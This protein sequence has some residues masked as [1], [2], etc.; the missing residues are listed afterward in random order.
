MRHSEPPAET[1]VPPPPRPLAELPTS[2]PFGRMTLPPRR[3]LR[4]GIA[5]LRGRVVAAA[6]GEQRA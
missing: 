3:S 4:T 1:D 6:T 5:H 2:S